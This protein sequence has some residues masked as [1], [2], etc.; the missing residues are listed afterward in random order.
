MM[1]ERMMAEARGKTHKQKS[2]RPVYM[3][4]SISEREVRANMRGK[5][6]SRYMA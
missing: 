4:N 2:T 6:D 5:R 3:G 1:P